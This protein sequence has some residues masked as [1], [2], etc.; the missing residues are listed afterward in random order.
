MGIDTKRA[1]ACYSSAGAIV[2]ADTLRVW[3]PNIVVRMLCTEPYTAGAAPLP[4][5]GH[6]PAYFLSAPSAPLTKAVPGSLS[7]EGWLEIYASSFE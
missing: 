7:L 6:V 4:D 5:H 2:A 1:V 3:P